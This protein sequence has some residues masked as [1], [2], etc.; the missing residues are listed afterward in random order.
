M[1]LETTASAL[2]GALSLMSK[3]VE[4]RATIPLLQS[5][6]FDGAT[7]SGTDLDNYLSIQLACTRAEGRA[8]ILLRPLA[9]L[10][11]HMGRDETISLQAGDQG[12]TL[13]FSG[14][15]YDLP[16]VEWDTLELGGDYDTVLP[17]DGDVFREGLRFCKAFMSTEDTRYYLNG[18]C[19]DGDDIVATDG[20]RMGVYRA[21]SKAS[22]LGRP[23]I[24]SKTVG[25]LAAFCAPKAVWIDKDRKAMRFE[26]PGMTLHAKLID[27]T[28]PDWRR[29]VP[30]V[31]NGI[32][33]RAERIKLTTTIARMC[34]VLDFGFRGGGVALAYDH[35]GIVICG[36][37]WVGQSVVAREYLPEAIATGTAEP[38]SIEF[39]PNYL[40]E[41]LQQF[42][43]DDIVRMG[44][45]GTYSP[46]IMRG[47]GPSYAVLMPMREG[48]RDLALSTLK[49]WPRA[50]AAA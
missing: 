45:D 7:L 4:R 46:M 50:K 34:D 16:T 35:E 48:S 38:G 8:A 30:D 31:S 44:I 36:R 28:F 40:R 6:R 20:H 49:E 12:A 3:V 1:K 5:V 33:I 18:V 23:I 27:G 47:S 24:P 29:V 17:V 39:N 9:A 25:L 13:T 22:D 10:V 43:R 37:T 42:H 2:K 41:V 15:R 26:L 21:D 11:R 19:L 32:E 14:G